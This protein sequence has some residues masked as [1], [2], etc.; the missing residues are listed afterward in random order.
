MSGSTWDVI[1]QVML[2]N[3]DR[4]LVVLEGKTDVAY[5]KRAIELQKVSNPVYEQ[6]RTDFM[7][8]GGAD[9]MKFFI[10]D[11]LE[12]IPQ[13]KKI[14]VFFDRDDEGKKGAAALLGLAETNEKIV[15]Y[16]D[17]TKDNLT[18][19]FIPYRDGVTGGDFLIED[20]FLW[21]KTIKSMV[22]K[23][24]ES[25][26]H[27]L[28]NLPKLSSRIKSALSEKYMTFSKEEFDG[29]IPLLDKILELI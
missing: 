12:I 3:S 10:N 17:I 28:K 7:S 20:Y 13:Q 26:H 14:V 25:S 29:F 2:L 9:N 15:R 11:L 1:G 5:V 8:A 22:D 27:P 23:A 16:G 19:S 21:D 6:I 18:V 4:P 24:I